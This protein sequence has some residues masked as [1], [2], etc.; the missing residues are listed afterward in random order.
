MATKC[1][2]PAADAEWLDAQ[3]WDDYQGK[4]D[5]GKMRRMIILSI[6][7]QQD[8]HIFGNGASAGAGVKFNKAGISIDYAFSGI[9]YLENIHRFSI[10]YKL[11]HLVLWGE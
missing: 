11:D 6:L 4:I 7:V 9:S 3:G 8:R 1:R 2:L 10:G 5:A